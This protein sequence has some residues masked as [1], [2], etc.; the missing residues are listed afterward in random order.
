MIRPFSLARL[1]TPLRTLT[2]DGPEED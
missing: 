1:A 2:R